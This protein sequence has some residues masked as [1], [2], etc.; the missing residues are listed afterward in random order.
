[1]KSDSANHEHLAFKKGD[2]QKKSELLHS[3]CS[4]YCMWQPR[5]FSIVSLTF[6]NS[7]Q[8]TNVNRGQAAQTK[9]AKTF[10]SPRVS[11]SS[12]LSSKRSREITVAKWRQ[13]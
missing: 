6:A 11:L 12:G 7:L 2:G 9:L 8:G 5:R 4:P 10:L 1:M 3:P 13:D